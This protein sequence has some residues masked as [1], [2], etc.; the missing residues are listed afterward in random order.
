[1]KR[2]LH[3]S[4]ACAFRGLFIAFKTERNLKIHLAAMVVAVGVGFYL[5]L[6]L[7]EWCLVIF[8]I[9]F[10]LIAELLNTALERLCDETHGGKQNQAI[11]NCKDI[12]AAAVL[13][14][15]LTAFIIGVLILIMPLFRKLLE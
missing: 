15:A 10:V 9:G 11:K 8:A 14:S 6:S 12:S 3:K 1:M 13:L 2:P 7:L 5:R 4:F